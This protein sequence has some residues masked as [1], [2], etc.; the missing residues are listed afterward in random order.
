MFMM[1]FDGVHALVPTPLTKETE[2]DIDSLRSVIDFELENGVKGVG[3]LAA[4]G[5]GYL[6]SIKDWKNVV[7][8]A[9]DQVNGRGYVNVGCASMG[10][11]QAVDMARS[12]EDIG[13]D[14]VLAFNPQGM[15]SYTSDELYIHFKAIA[16]A[17]DIEV[18][19]YARSG[20]LIPF[21]VLERLVDEERIHYMKYAY[22]SCSLLKKLSEELG[23]K[24]YLFCGADSW[25]LRYLLL[26][27][28]GIFHA[29]AAVFPK[30]NVELLEHIKNDR[31]WEARKIWYERLLTWNDSGFFENWQWAHKYALMLMGV[32]ETDV[33]YPPQGQGEDYHRAE[34]EALLRYQNKI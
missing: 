30:E 1:D 33:M 20:D 10:T 5:E 19:P 27:C 7:E 4:I 24:L 17:V 6:L 26:G 23:D 12:A 3:V 2:I 13:A 28:N 18:V 22:R 31:V 8:T 9:V 29:T 21:E 11:K 32:L 34:I 15:R 14:S 16:D 25:T